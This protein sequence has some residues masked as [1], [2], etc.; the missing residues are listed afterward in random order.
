MKFY[1]SDHPDLRNVQKAG[2]LCLFCQK[3]KQCFKRISDLKVHA[4]KCHPDRVDKLADDVF[5]ENNG[6]WWSINPADY[7]R[8]IRPS[9]R[10]S[11]AAVSIRTIILDWANFM[12]AKVSRSREGFLRSWKETQR[13]EVATIST[14]EN[15]PECVYFD[16]EDDFVLSYVR[17][18]PGTVF[19]DIVIGVEKLRLF[20]SDNIFK[21]NSALRS[22]SRRLGALSTDALPFI[23]FEGEKE[24][25]KSTKG[26]LAYLSWHI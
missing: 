7:S 26:Q 21:N 12:G 25:S 16:V 6:Y 24:I 19:V 10:T 5:S 8:L 15:L 4:K 14:P 11:L 18:I 9:E 23:N 2:A 3:S 22:L 1:G 17:L 20:L 13:T